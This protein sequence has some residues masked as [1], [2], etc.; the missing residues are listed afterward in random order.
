MKMSR[1][2]IFAIARETWYTI[3]VERKRKVSRN[4]KRKKKKDDKKQHHKAIDVVQVLKILEWNWLKKTS[5]AL[6]G[7]AQ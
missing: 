4:Q 5:L 3:Q 6:T 2:I 1:S 7:M